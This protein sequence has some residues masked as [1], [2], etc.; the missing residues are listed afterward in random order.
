MYQVQV[1]YVLS[2]NLL[3]ALDVHLSYELSQHKITYYELLH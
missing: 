2:Y 1:I 3:S